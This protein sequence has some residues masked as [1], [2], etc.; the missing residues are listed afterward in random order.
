MKNENAP[1]ENQVQ[2]HFSSA[3]LIMFFTL[4]LAFSTL[5]HIVNSI[6]PVYVSHGLLMYRPQMM[7]TLIL[8]ASRVWMV[9][10]SP[11]LSITH[12]PQTRNFRIFQKQSSI[13]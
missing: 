3:I 1:K 7:L 10:L 12:S 8:Y 5:Q 9:N 13:D 11:A 6:V 2:Y 4:H